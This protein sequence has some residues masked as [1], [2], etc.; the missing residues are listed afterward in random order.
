MKR[1]LKIVR[2]QPVDLTTK[3]KLKPEQLERV[4]GYAGEGKATKYDE[5]GELSLTLVRRLAKAKRKAKKYVL[6]TD[7]IGRRLYV[8]DKTKV[9]LAP[10]ETPYT[11]NKKEALI[12]YYGF[13]D[14]EV[15]RTWYGGYTGIFLWQTLN[16]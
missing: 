9:D 12:F 14:P 6:F 2:K 5:N 10:Y 1:R 15:K 4:K 16:V 7:E 3:T 11:F 8:A 13:D